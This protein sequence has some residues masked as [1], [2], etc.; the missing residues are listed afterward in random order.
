MTIRI[1]LTEEQASEAKQALLARADGL[2]RAAGRKT[3]PSPGGY[4]AQ[5]RRLDAIALILNGAL[6]AADIAQDRAARFAD[7]ERAPS[8]W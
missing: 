8:G 5:A 4:Y 6:T 7:A 1:E 2:K 3:C